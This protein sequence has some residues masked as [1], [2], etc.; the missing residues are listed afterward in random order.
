MAEKQRTEIAAQPGPQ[1]DFLASEADIA[2]YGGAAGGGKTFALLLEP[3]RH[4]DNSRFGGVIFRRLTTQIRNE[5]GL[6]DESMTL[7]SPLSATPKESTLEW[8][9]PSGMR[10]KFAHLEHEKNVYDWQGAQVPFLGFDELTQFTEKQFFYL[11]SRNR[12]ASGVPGYV[13]ATT[14]PD[15]RSWVRQ[16][17]AWWID[18]ETGYPIK[19]RSGVLR[20]FIRKDDKIVWAD[21]AAELVAE[22]GIEAKPKSVTF[23]GSSIYDNKILMDQDPSYLANLEALPR[24]ERMQLKDGNWNVQ[25]AAG[26]FFRREW[27]PVVDVLPGGWISVIRFWDRAAT[28]PNEH[29]RDPDWTR[30]VKLYKYPDGTYVAADLRSDRDTPGK[31][32]TLIKNT[33]SQDGVAVKIMSQQDPGSAG[34]S[35]GEHFIKML[36]GYDV[37]TETMSK[38]KVTRA[39]PASAQSEAGNIRVLRAPWNDDFFSE[40]DNFPEGAHDDIVDAFSGAFNKLSG[41]MAGQFS[42]E[43]TEIPK[44]GTIAGRYS[45]DR[46]W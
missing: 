37:S 39:K 17:I 23:I 3:M 1:E 22:Y 31:I 32:E 45:E 4:I 42:R 16:F 18:P 30:G 24:V 28:K 21:T 34:V 5:G 20:W 2:F 6:W 25:A 36:A 13:R 10:M 35:E 33:A 8:A 40:M 41:G 38:D 46:A 19:E 7:Y 14:N 43:F 26:M 27:F 44:S 29:N 12:S 9:F 11:L 15:S